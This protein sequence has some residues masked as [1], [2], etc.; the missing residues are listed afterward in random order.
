MLADG[1]EEAFSRRLVGWSAFATSG[2]SGQGADSDDGGSNPCRY[3]P[4]ACGWLDA[5]DHA[6][7][8]KHLGVSHMLVHRVWARAGIKPQ[9]IR[10][11]V[12]SDDPDFETKAA[13][14]IRSLGVPVPDS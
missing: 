4:Q 2:Q 8:A 5:L 3:S 1:E 7:A 13:D 14:V 12:L 11:Y 10:R 6:Q 9:S